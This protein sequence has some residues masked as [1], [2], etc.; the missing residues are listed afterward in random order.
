MLFYKFNL[1]IRRIVKDIL[2][3]LIL[4]GYYKIL[5]AV[6]VFNI[7][8]KNN[9]GKD[10]FFFTNPKDKITILALDSDRY[11]GDLEAL[12]N[13]NEFRVLY[14]SQKAPGWLISP[15]YNDNELKKYINAKKYSNDW[16]AHNNAYFF[17]TT[18]LKYFYSYISV[19]CVTTVNYRYI[20]DYNWAKASDK[21]GVP[22]IMFYRECLLAADRF[23]NSIYNRTKYR[24][25]H[26]HGSHI[27]VHNNIV[28][29]LFIDTGYCKKREISTCGALRMDGFL[30]LIRSNIEPSYDH[31]FNKKFVLFYFHYDQSLFG[32]E[33]P[34]IEDEK[35]L[36]HGSVW[37]YREQ[38][39]K[40]LH[41]AIIELAEE[42]KDIQF[43][44]KPKPI[45]MQHKSWNKY[46][47][48]ISKSSINVH[49]LKNYVVD[50]AIDA[51]ELILNSDIVCGL[52][53]S[54][55]LESAVAGK[56]VIFPVFYDYLKSEHV[57][58]F[59]WKDSLDLFD[60]AT[61][62]DNFKNIFYSCL[63]SHNIDVN[64]MNKR[65]KLFEL[66]FDTRQSNSLR[67]YSD[68]IKKVVDRKLH[69]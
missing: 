1:V 5:V 15:F 39:F 32:R 41:E 54:T 69:S 26:F 56:R 48:I 55:V 21:I 43:I 12:S 59:F 33:N 50:A 19:D 8:E 46:E 53:S 63:N 67:R 11:R 24:F 61:S 52:Q 51:Q 40:D 6:V 44:I 57:N 62:K 30:D 27:I 31:G 64:I 9:N 49:N 3:Y 35:F 22:F 2:K 42:N 38:L 37:G 58:D 18:F 36:Y 23:Y 28:K 14:M 68:T 20:E 47:E 16:N 17:M 10:K 65:K 34:T 4:N 66:Y 25:G 7:K 13:N 45:M 60:I 29:E